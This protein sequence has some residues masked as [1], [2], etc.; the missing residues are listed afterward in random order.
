MATNIPARNRITKIARVQA[1]VLEFM[2]SLL[3]V[4]KTASRG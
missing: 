1:V 2:M 3:I 4:I